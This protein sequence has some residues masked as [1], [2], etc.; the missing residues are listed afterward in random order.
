MVEPIF[1]KSDLSIIRGEPNIYEHRSTGSGK[2]VFVHFCANCGTKLYLTFERFEDVVGIYGGTF[3]NPNWF[4][5]TPEI[6]KHI[7]LSVAQ[8]GTII[9]AGVDT[10]EGHAT[11]NEGVPIEPHVFSEPKTID[12]ED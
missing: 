6:S 9:P 5:R 12:T 8:H 2:Q 7:F 4:E 10:F 1:T 11:T 3:D